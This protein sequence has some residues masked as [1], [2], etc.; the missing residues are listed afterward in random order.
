MSSEVICGE[1][2]FI[3]L[4]LN[5]VHW[6]SVDGIFCCKCHGPKV[7]EIKCPYAKRFDNPKDV[8]RERVEN[9]D[10]LYQIQIGIYEMKTCDFVIYTTKGINV[11]NI[12]FNWE[13]FD[14]ISQLFSIKKLDYCFRKYLF[15]HVFESLQ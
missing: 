6:I 13:F 7:V 3:K 5:A 9:N 10:Y 2:M 14:T 11:V 1:K 8:S 12:E 4:C 15:P